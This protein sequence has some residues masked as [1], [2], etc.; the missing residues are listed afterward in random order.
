MFSRVFFGFLVCYKFLG[1]FLVLFCFQ[2]SYLN[3]QFSCILGVYD[4]LSHQRASTGK[5]SKI[6]NKYY[7]R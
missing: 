6:L 1:G 2:G 7:I 4:L 5:K 3:S